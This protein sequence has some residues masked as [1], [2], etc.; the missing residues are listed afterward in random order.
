MV[1][2]SNSKDR[3]ARE[4]TEAGQVFVHSATCI[5]VTSVAHTDKEIGGAI[6]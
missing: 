4:I 1:V 5:S 6:T 3:L 2:L